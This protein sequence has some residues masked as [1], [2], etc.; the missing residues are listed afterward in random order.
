MR[1]ECKNAEFYS[2]FEIFVKVICKKIANQSEVGK[3]P[4][5]YTLMVHKFLMS[6]F[7]VFSLT[8]SKSA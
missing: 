5:F 7:F 8:V 1:A 2:D 4:L 6:K 3:R